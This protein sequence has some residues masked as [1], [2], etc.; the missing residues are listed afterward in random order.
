MN[1]IIVINN[2]IFGNLIGENAIK[3]DFFL[4][5]LFVLDH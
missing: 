2:Q 4:K 5:M 3:F 1:P